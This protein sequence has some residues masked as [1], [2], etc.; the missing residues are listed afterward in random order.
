MA[1]EIPGASIEDD[2]VL[3]DLTPQEAAALTK[4][5]QDVLKKHNAEMGVKSAIELLKRVPAKSTEPNPADAAT[6]IPTPYPIDGKD[7]DTTPAGN[8]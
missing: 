3:E 7:E 6:A 1:E 8:A 5:L 4:D 2:Y